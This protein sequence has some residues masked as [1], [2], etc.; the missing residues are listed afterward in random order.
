MILLVNKHKHL[1]H[2]RLYNYISNVNMQSISLDVLYYVLCI[3]VLSPCLY[4]CIDN[5]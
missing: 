2:N 4:V 3:N 1:F 5:D